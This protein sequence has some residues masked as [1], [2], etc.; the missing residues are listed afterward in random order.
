MD[1]KIYIF[2]DEDGN[3]YELNEHKKLVFDALINSHELLCL[4]NYNDISYGACRHNLCNVCKVIAHDNDKCDLCDAFYCKIY[5]KNNEEHNNK[6]TKD[7]NVCPCY[8]KKKIINNENEYI[9]LN[10]Y[11]TT[12]E[13]LLKSCAKALRDKRYFPCCV[14]V[15]DNCL[16]K[17]K[18]KSLFCKR[19]KDMINEK[20]E[21]LLDKINVHEFLK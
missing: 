20:Y 9:L 16:Q 12:E 15:C 17:H 7:V 3:K 13:E 2:T 18:D 4:I 5:A 14:S 19:H 8:L 11:T 10:I 21:A 6:I 1:K